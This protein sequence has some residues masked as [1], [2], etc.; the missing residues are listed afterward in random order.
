MFGQGVLAQTSISISPLFIGKAYFCSYAS[1]YRFSSFYSE[2]V[3]NDVQNPYFN[4]SAKKFSYRPSIKIGLQLEFKFNKDKHRLGFEWAQDASGTMSKSTAFVHMNTLGIPDSL[5]PDN[6]SYGNYT[7]YFMT[8]FL[9]NRL[10]FRYHRKI[11]SNNLMFVTYIIPEATFIFGRE[12]KSEWSFDMDTM[13]NNSTFYH[14]NARI[15]RNDILSVYSGKS[16][17]MLG[18]GLKSDIYTPKKHIYLFSIDLS[19]KQGFKTIIAT[20]DNSIFVDTGKKI[21]IVNQ[22]V[23]RGSGLY[24]QISRSFTFKSWN[25]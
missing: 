22:L 25:K 5:K 21:G 10:S 15:V 14:N 1:D 6:I 18:I 24:F 20:I 16:S 23:S 4:Y 7:S 8:G 17:L 19:Y 9:Y 11:T 3:S 13:T 12:N 2:Q